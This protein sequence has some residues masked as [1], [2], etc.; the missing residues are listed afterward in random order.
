MGDTRVYVIQYL[1]GSIIYDLTRTSTVT[2]KDKIV[3]REK[4]KK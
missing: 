4:I 1:L 3:K 2:I